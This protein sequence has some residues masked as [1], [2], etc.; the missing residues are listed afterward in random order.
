ML[1]AYPGVV[2]GTKDS[3]GDGERIERICREFPDLI[4]FAGTEKY[5]L[6]TLRWGGD[7]CISATVNVTARQ[8]REVYDLWEA[9]EDASAAQAALTER[10]EFLD[11]FPIDPGA[12]GAGRLAEPAPAASAAGRRAGAHDQLVGQRP[13]DSGRSCMAASRSSP[14][15]RPLA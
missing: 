9:G 1:D 4:V 10:R 2:V 11:G 15:R 7:G 12:E 5:L 3:S 14:A 13:H 6:D 8:A